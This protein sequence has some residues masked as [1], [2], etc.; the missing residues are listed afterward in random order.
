M[1]PKP[2]RCLKIQPDL[3][4]AAIGEA[5][6]AAVRRVQGHLDRCAPCR[7]EFNRYQ[8]VEE[9]VRALRTEPVRATR[10]ARAREK[11]E[12]RLA[13]L[14]SRLL[15]YRIF[16]SPLGNILI[17][18][19]DQGVS[20]VEYL[21]RGATFKS[22]RLSRLAGFEVV[23]DGDEMETLHLELL[24]FLNGKRTRFEWPL[25]LR[26]ARSDFHRAVLQATSKIPYGAVVS[27]AG[28]ASTVGKP[29]AVRAVAQALRWNPLPI[30]VPCHRIVGTSGSL[31][32]YAGN[33]VDLKQRLLAAE[34]IPTVKLR[35]DLRIAREAMYVRYPDD[36]AFCLPTCPSLASVAPAH[37]TFF[38]TCQCAE[39]M[40]LAPCDTC[41]PDLHPI[42]Q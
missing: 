6:P 7:E 33:R 24:E 9:V 28:M 10:I 31:T 27:Y 37:L 21:A 14:Q 12:S 2:P 20:L 30:V 3:L 18:R 22:S 26:L 35:R 13:D 23:E 19:S 32:G 36:Q 8:A 4:G 5:T 39:A 25:D 41:R 34:G 16:P 29:A 11:L 1:S 17:A 38:G 42:S 15:T 40:G